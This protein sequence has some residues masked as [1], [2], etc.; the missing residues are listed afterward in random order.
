MLLNLLSIFTIFT[1]FFSIHKELQI[2]LIIFTKYLLCY[3]QKNNIICNKLDNMIDI[4]V[5]ISAFPV[6][7]YSSFY[8]ILLFLS[9]IL[10]YL[11]SGINFSNNSKK[12]EKSLEMEL[13]GFRILLIRSDFMSRS[14][15]R[16]YHIR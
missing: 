12:Y 3:H 16:T 1:N 2:F 7:N 10:C 11:S 9:F 8:S 5:H 13:S 4:S 14:P 6:N 15:C